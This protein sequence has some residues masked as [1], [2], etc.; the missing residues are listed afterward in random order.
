MEN[1]QDIK[2]ELESIKKIK[3]DA[4]YIEL[5]KTIKIILILWFLSVVGIVA[6]FLIY[7]NQFE[8]ET[9]TETETIYTQEGGSCN[10]INC[11]NQGDVINGAV[12]DDKNKN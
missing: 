8:V 1:I 3:E 11:V 4:T 10:N 7:L 5:I 6:G 9:I 12:I 2:R